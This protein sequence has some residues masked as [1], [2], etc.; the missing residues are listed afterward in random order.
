MSDANMVEPIGNQVVVTIEHNS[1]DG[2][3]IPD[4]ARERS[5]I[6]KVLAIGEAVDYIAVGDNVIAPY[7]GGSCIDDEM[8][9]ID[10]NE[11]MG[12]VND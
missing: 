5:R 7:E 10:A 6:V 4:I 1:G 2:I 11:I 8:R 3:V 12:V 9:V